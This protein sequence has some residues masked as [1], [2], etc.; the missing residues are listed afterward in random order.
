MKRL[1][2][3][4]PHFPIPSRSTR[5][6]P[7]ERAVSASN[8]PR[9]TA[10][11]TQSAAADPSDANRLSLGGFQLFPAGGENKDRVAVHQRVR[12]PD[13]ARDTVLRGTRKPFALGTGELRIRCHD[14][15]SQC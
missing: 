11:A 7:D 3:G 4:D 1:D 6:R 15:R 14:L 12:R 13:R 5:A 8:T 2:T 9:A 10:R